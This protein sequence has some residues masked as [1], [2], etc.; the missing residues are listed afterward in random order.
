M[1]FTNIGAQQL[2]WALGSNISN[3]FIQAIAIGSGSGTVSV[4]NATLVAEHTRTIQTGSPN[5]TTAR[6]VSFQ[7]DFNSLVMSGLTLFEFG[8][9]ASGTLNTGSIWQREAFGSVIFDGTQEL[10][11]TTTLEVLPG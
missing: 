7:G 8:L 11:V 9:F 4:T 2:A 3:N 1:G 6:K 10:Q 5:F